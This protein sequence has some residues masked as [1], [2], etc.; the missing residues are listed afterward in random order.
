VIDA[1]RAYR[2]RSGSTV[3]RI[4]GIDNS[5]DIVGSYYTGTGGEKAFLENNG[6]YED[7]TV[8]GSQY[9]HIAG[10]NK[11]GQ[12]FGQYQASS[13]QIHGFDYSTSGGFWSIDVPGAVDISVTGDE[14]IGG[15][16][17]GG[18]NYGLA[19]GYYLDSSGN[20]HG[21]LDYNGT[22]S[23]FDVPGATNTVIS[24]INQSGEI[25]GRYTD[26]LGTHG[27]VNE[28]GVTYKYDYPGAAATQILGVNDEGQFYG[29][30]TAGGVTSGF[31]ASLSLFDQAVPDLHTNDLTYASTASGPTHF[32]DL[33]NFE[34]SYT[35]LVAAFGTNRAAMQQWLNIHQPL[36]NR[37]ETFDGLH[38]VASYSDLM[39][40]FSGAG[41]MKAVQDAGASH[42]ISNG[43]KE[44]RTTSFNGLDYIASSGDLINA[45]GANGDA[46]A[47]HYIE[48]GVKE[49]RTTTFDG[50]DYIASYGDLIKAF[51]D[52]EQDG[53]AHFIAN[54]YKEGRSTTFDGLAYIAQYA[55][56]I[57]AFSANN[58]AGAAHYINN[59]H[60]EGRSTS[61][62]VGAYESAH[63]DLMGKFSSND[64]FLTAYINTYKATGT[65]LT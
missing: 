62:N 47:Y 30:Y 21:F 17:T 57:N 3:T 61:F 8:A 37:V 26:A 40:A 25:V 60:N 2:S 36:E 31:V 56:L 4:A 65:F 43:E 22:V 48:S 1:V 46:G 35:D 29:S 41:S 33:Q 44:G 9:T 23:T 45:F 53:A 64:A 34:A 16:S 7:L 52:N 38:Y 32:I 13:G 11:Y 54:G 49:G 27:F 63:P 28:Y 51:G 18:A 15:V 6:S 5:G 58:D 19:V 59:G 24:G 20:D 50:L 10:I 42:Y 39:A 12:V 55:D 14:F